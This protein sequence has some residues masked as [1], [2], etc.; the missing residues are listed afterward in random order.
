MSDF[1]DLFRQEQGQPGPKNDQPFD[2]EAWVQK[3]QEQ[4]EAVYTLIDETATAVAGDGS[5][6]QKYLDVQSRFDRYSV[7]NA[8]LIQIGRPHV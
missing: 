3:K 6:F 5:I 8:L 7:S 4:R 2:K 1:D